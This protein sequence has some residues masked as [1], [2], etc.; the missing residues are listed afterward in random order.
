MTPWTVAQQAPLSILSVGFSRQEYQSGCHALL[1]G[2]LPNPGIKPRSSTLQVDSLPTEPPGKPK[3]T[4]VGS[5]SLLQGIFLTQ[6]LNRGLLHCRRILYQ[7]SYRE[8][9]KEPVG[10]KQNANLT[11]PSSNPRCALTSCTTLTF[12]LISQF[13]VSSP[14]KWG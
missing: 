5:L 7:L 3:N 1:Q 14:I 13:Q 12:V 2:N 4:G 11:Y 8:A 9:P 10:R 6:E